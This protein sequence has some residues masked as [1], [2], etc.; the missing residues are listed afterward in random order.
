MVTKR[1][2]VY[3]EQHWLPRMGEHAPVLDI[4][5]RDYTAHYP[6]LAGTERYVSVDIDE[7]Q[8]PDIVADVT[9]PT[10]VRLAAACYP[11][12]G[13]ILFNGMIGYGVDTPAALAASLHNLASLLREGGLL[14]VGWNERDVSRQQLFEVL[15]RTGLALRSVEG[16]EV[17]EPEETPGYE[18]LRHHYTCWQRG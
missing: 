10:L 8:R 11:A 4:G 1:S 9:S 6:R 15:H 16:H 3:L 13:G 7:S 5:K 18:Y 14:L 17:F 2:R 12:Y